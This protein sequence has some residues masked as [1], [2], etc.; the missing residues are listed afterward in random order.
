M[1]I[2]TLAIDIETYS[3]TNLN[4]SGV[5]RYCEST[6]FEILLFSYSV[7]EGD[8]K[9]IDLARGEKIPKEIIAA[10][11]DGKIIKW[12]FYA[13]FER[14]CISKYLGYPTGKYLSPVSWRCSMVWSAYLDL[15][16]SLAGVGKVLGLEKQKLFEGKSL[17]R[18]FC[19]S[20]TPTLTNNKRERNKPTDALEKWEQF[21]KY[22][23][24]DVEVELAVKKRLSKFPVPDFVWDEYHVDQMIN[25]TGVL[26]DMEFALQAIDMDNKSKTEITKK[27]I[28]ITELENPNS[29]MQMKNWL[30]ENG[31]KVESL[32]KK[33]VKKLIKTAPLLL[34]EALELR[35][36]LAKSS[37]K[38]YKL[39]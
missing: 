2:N 38:K 6:D 17:I 24:R 37:V 8:V 1:K 13:S 20:C 21:V 3:A 26:V 7:N 39:C 5:Y 31:L 4:K 29:V 19:G 16:L 25:D 34:R 10:I 11:K 12:A 23:I 18:Y 35:L 9:V 22:N 27:M 28:N 33:E 30:N 32:G 15:P 36:Q 14:I